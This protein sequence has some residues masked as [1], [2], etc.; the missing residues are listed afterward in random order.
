MVTSPSCHR[1]VTPIPPKE[2]TPLPQ[3]TPGPLTGSAPPDAITRFA[4]DDETKPAVDHFNRVAAKVGWPQ[5]AK[6]TEPR[7]ASLR[8]RLEEAG[9]LAG[10]VQ[11]IERGGLSDWLT[12]R[13]SKGWRAD[14]DFFLQASS[15]TKLRE[16]SYDNRKTL[17]SVPDRRDIAGAFD[18]LEERL[19]G[20][21][22][23]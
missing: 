10:W 9:G 23:R 12:G 14:I 17:T 3:N 11:A 7:R 2:I 18:R 13:T 4:V 21:T 22:A 19:A 1:Q 15:F 8:K 16:G 5:C 6:L 20:F